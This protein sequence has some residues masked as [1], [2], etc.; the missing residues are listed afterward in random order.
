[1]FL[2]TLCDFF[3]LAKREKLK[4]VNFPIYNLCIFSKKIVTF[5]K[6]KAFHDQE[7]SV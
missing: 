5:A 2:A 6:A 3:F 7:E 1:M 4:N